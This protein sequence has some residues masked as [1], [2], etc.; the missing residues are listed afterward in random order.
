MKIDLSGQSALVTGASRGIG[1]AV[2]LTLAGAGASVAVTARSAND[3]ETLV[4]EIRA[5]GGR[6]LALP[7]DLTQLDHLESLV[8]SC[9]REYGQLNILVNNA[10]VTEGVKFADMTFESWSRVQRINVDGAMRLMQ[11]AIAGMATRGSGRIIN[12]ASIAGKAGLRYS[13]A[14]TASKHALLGLTRSVALDYAARGVTLNCVCPGWVQTEMIETTLQNIQEKTGRSREEATHSLVK[15]V[16]MAR[17]IAPEEVAALVA[18][19]ASSFAAG[20]TGQGINIDG[21][22]VQN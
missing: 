11:L 18:F 10:G 17:L 14:Y 12:I 21:G 3:L 6:A 7:C 22:L 1:R 15:D 9:Q 4:G 2:A 20:I 19:L 13:A 8:S 5:A 16:P